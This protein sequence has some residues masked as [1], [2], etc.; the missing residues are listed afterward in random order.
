MGTVAART[1]TTSTPTRTA[2]R[3]AAARSSGARRDRA[4]DNAESTGRQL[5]AH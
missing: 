2:M 5:N 1:C 3:R 4:T